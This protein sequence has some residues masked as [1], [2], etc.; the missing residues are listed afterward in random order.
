MF[1]HVKLVARYGVV[2]RD[3]FLLHLG[4][5]LE[6]KKPTVVICPKELL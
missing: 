2:K 4:A 1:S 5:L 3:P 6:I